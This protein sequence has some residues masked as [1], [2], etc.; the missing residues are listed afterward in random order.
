[1]EP[2]TDPFADQRAEI[3]TGDPTERERAIRAALL[4]IALGVILALLARGRSSDG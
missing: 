1:M 4:G 3:P 2:E